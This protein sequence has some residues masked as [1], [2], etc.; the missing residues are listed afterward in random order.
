MYCHR[1]T[2]NF[3]CFILLASLMALFGCGGSTTED[4]ADN[5][6]IITGT[7]AI[8][9]TVMIDSD[10]NDT[11]A[12]YQSNDSIKTAQSLPNP[13]SVG[14]YVNRP[15]SGPQG[16]SHLQGDIDDY[17][18]TTLLEGQ[19][20]RLVV[21]KQEDIDISEENNLEL[22]L[23]NTLGEVF[24]S[25]RSGTT[26]SLTVGT[27]GEYYI[28]VRALSGASNYLLNLNLDS[29]Q[30]VA[31]QSSEQLIH[32]DLDITR[33]FV[34]GEVIVKFR[35][36]T[37][38]VLPAAKVG[39]LRKKAG[40]RGRSTLFTLD[41]N[42]ND[43]SP[44][45]QG[46][47]RENLKRKTLDIIKSLRQRSDVESARPNYIRRASAIPNDPYYAYQWHYPQINL[48]QAWEITTG[49]RIDGGEVIV[50]V[51]DTGILPDHPDLQGRLVAGYDF[52]RDTHNSGD[53]D[54]IDDNPYDQGDGDHTPSSFHG[55]HVAGTVAA[56]SNNNLGVAGVAWD[57]K[58]M[59]LRVLGKDGGTDYDIEQAIRYAAGLENDSGRIPA[60]KAD[61]I[62]LS[63][64]G[65][66]DSTVPPEAFVLA[67][68]AGVIIVA[69][70]GNEASDQLNYPASLNGV[71]SVSAVGIDKNIAYYSNYGS[72]VDLAAPGGNTVTDLDSNGFAD[73]VL[74]T[75]AVEEVNIE[76]LYAFY[77]GTSMAAPHVAGVVALMKA[78]YPGMTPQQFDQW[79]ESGLLT[80]DLGIT[81]RDNDYGYGLIDAHKAVEIA[82]NA[83]GNNLSELEPVIDASVSVLNF[84][85]NQNELSFTLRNSGGGYLT[86]SDIH[87]EDTTGWLEIVP[88]AVNE[89]GLGEYSA[90]LNRAALPNQGIA[91]AVIAVE[92]SAGT[93]RLPVLAISDNQLSQ[94]D[95]GVHYI[96]LI[97]VSSGLVV[98]QVRSVAIN[99]QYSFSIEDI[100]YGNYILLA[101]SNP[102]NNG[103]ICDAAEACG[104][105]PSV[106]IVEEITINQSSPP[107]ANFNFETNFNQIAISQ[108]RKAQYLR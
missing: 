38:A 56:A 97:D 90:V 67:R 93:L 107:V 105:Y 54:G 31:V 52:I 13:V 51:I 86:I 65:I 95:A 36:N 76:Y 11:N 82:S 7:I 9:S 63:L 83:Y 102:D 81:G 108:G 39:L 10:V 80:E 59:P 96:Q 18:K 62:N 23:T 100:P 26:K 12:A 53:G 49:A 6:K 46:R 98:K 34:P 30:S 16:R 70:A 78:V 8:P 33:E 61:V 42:T 44:A 55:T 84:S 25:Q 66:T 101:G 47:K 69:A 50:A 68:Q 79:L 88:V 40:G 77:Q 64:S 3:R 87:N 92:S 41:E 89:S 22:S 43:I 5:A 14:G 57:A 91:T 99:E 48:P 35:N 2:Y 71:V 15:G 24:V 17:F 103:F 19:V 45:S 27:T 28:R 29:L 75:L 32:K 106:G 4:M 1:I 37:Q 58:V 72:T 73:G 21:G 94:R 85:D 20:V 104:Q 74:S 60:Q